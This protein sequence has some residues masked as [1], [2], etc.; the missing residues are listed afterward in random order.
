[1]IRRLSAMLAACTGRPVGHIE[2][3]TPSHNLSLLHGAGRLH[4][5][6]SR[7]HRDPDSITLRYASADC[8]MAEVFASQVGEV[9]VL[10]CSL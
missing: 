4:R 10:A 7:P 9:A 3:W 1:M 8:L 6:P 2:T 5:A